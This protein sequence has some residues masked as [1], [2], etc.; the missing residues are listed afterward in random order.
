MVVSCPA[1]F[2]EMSHV[3]DVRV[4]I[5]GCD[6]QGFREWFVAFAIKEARAGLLFRYARAGWQSFSTAGTAR[7]PAAK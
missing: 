6:E 7:I 1:A 3:A 4:R 5:F 2:V